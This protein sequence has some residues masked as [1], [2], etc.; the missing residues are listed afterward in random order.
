MSSLVGFFKVG[1]T[2]QARVILTIEAAFCTPNSPPPVTLYQAR[3]YPPQNSE[4]R[5]G[6]SRGNSSRDRRP[7]PMSVHS[8]RMLSYNNRGMNPPALPVFK[9]GPRVWGVPMPD[10]YASENDTPHVC[11]FRRD[12]YN[13][14]IEC[15][16]FEGPF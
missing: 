6:L 11:I 2:V 13:S 5:I 1:A 7:V 4:T 14:C 15:C 3:C 9:W 12:I 16:A 8:P 10:W